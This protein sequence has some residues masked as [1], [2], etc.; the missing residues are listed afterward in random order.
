MNTA[1][2]RNREFAGVVRHAAARVPLALA[3]GKRWTVLGGRLHWTPLRPLPPPRK[4]G[5]RL[6]LVRR[7]AARFLTGRNPGRNPGSPWR[8][9]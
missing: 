8:Y 5:R 4:P 3:G 2:K 7:M 6:R 1:T 9:L